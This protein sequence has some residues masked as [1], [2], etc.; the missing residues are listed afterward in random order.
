MTTHLV[1][2]SFSGAEGRLMGRRDL[3]VQEA[4]AIDTAYRHL[5]VLREP[6]RRELKE[7]LRRY[8][9]SRIT[10]YDARLDREAIGRERA[11][12]AELEQDIWAQ[13][14]RASEQASDQRVLTFVLPAIDQMI[15]VRIAR[16]AT[17][18]AHIPLGVFIFLALLSL[19]CSFVAGMN[20]AGT[21][22][23]SPVY[24]YVFA[25]TM[26]LTAFMILNIE[27]PRAGLFPMRVL[28]EVL[29]QLRA[30]MS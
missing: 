4:G 21:E 16:E 11:R 18:R 20:M 3:I 24:V 17:L 27:F 26:A 15:D 5:D 1:A 19:A 30:T 22:P 8:L 28:D 2:L 9:D 10:Y 25:G 23:P 29:V 7:Q 13:A 14:V 12:S 6:A